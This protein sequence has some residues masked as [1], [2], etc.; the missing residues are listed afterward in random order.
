[1][2]EYLG[3]K[4]KNLDTDLTPFMKINSNCIITVKW[5]TTQLENNIGENLDC[6]GFGDDFLDM[7]PHHERKYWINWIEL[8]QN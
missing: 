3:K 7:T 6:L 8:H 2:W 5:K 1:M 4:K